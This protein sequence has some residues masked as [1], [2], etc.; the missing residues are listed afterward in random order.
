MSALQN[1]VTISKDKKGHE[2]THK[3]MQ[4]DTMAQKD[5]KSKS[6]HKKE[7]TG[8]DVKTHKKVAKKACK[9]TRR[10]DIKI[11]TCIIA[12]KFKDYT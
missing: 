8:K 7:K 5:V 2:K 10:R 6:T 9:E 11:H 1:S 3:K 12:L 4:K